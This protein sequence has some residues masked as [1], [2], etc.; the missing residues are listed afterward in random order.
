MPQCPEAAQITSVPRLQITGAPNHGRM[1]K[2][3]GQDW[4]PP[5]YEIQFKAFT[6][7]QV[8]AAG[9][10]RRQVEYRIE[11]KRFIR[12][13]GDGLRLATDPVTPQMLAYCAHLTWP[14]SIVCGPL[15]VALAGIKM[16]L[17]TINVSVPIQRK[18]RLGIT[19]HVWELKSTEICQWHGI[20]IT[21]RTRSIL[22]SLLLLPEPRALSAFSWSF[23][24]D[25]ITAKD[26]ES[27]LVNNPGRRGNNRLKGFLNRAR[28]GSMSHGEDRLHQIL[29]RAGIVGW[30]ANATIRDELGII[31]RPDVLFAHCK[32]IVEF[33]GR[34]FHGESRFQADRDRDNLL[35]S[36]GYM[37]L[38]FT[39]HDVTQ[40]PNYVAS[41]IQQALDNRAS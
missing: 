22:D 39:W 18:R 3:I 5:Q 34:A 12:V 40:R 10:S 17:T 11:T 14:D 35:V 6:T 2:L 24:R 31:A 9:L 19:P 8:L 36:L 15:A 7:D 13:A 25:L 37:I 23:T 32:L 26:L 20:P 33:D 30:Q 38:R 1:P 29:H 16:N 21:N 28:T 41:Q 27:F 4:L